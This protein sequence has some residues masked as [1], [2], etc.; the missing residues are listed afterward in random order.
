MTVH[1]INDF[2][3]IDVV[4]VDA[5]R[6]RFQLPDNRLYEFSD[7]MCDFC[8]T[9]GT[10]LESC[11]DEKKLYHCLFCHNHLQWYQVENDFIPPTGDKFQFLLPEGWSPEGLNRWY[12]KFKQRRLEQE[13]V[14][15]Q[16][17]EHGKNRF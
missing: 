5:A 10:V 1:K 13:K 8:W 16:I 15:D 2:S 4:V 14:K 3:E 9:G 11:G 6:D 7:H 12:E 17:L